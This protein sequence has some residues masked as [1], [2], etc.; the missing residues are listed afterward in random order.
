MHM[1]LLSMFYVDAG[2]LLAKLLLLK[3]R[4]VA[5]ITPEATSRVVT[6]AFCTINLSGFHHKICGEKRRCSAT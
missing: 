6:V 5:I 4:H 2:H 3:Q 1:K